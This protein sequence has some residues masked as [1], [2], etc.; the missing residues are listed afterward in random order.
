MER[1]LSLGPPGAGARRLRYGPAG[2]R[3]LAV[4]LKDIV[5]CRKVDISKVQKALKKQGVTIE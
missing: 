2:V 3:T 1:G 4:S 5:P